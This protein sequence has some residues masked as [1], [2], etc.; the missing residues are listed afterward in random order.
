MLDYNFF[1]VGHV[2]IYPSISNV[3]ITYQMTVHKR[4]I[5]AECSPVV[6]KHKTQLKLMLLLLKL[7][8]EDSRRMVSRIFHILFIL[9]SFEIEE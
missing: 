5:E 7:Y 3:Y 2:D 6:S 9:H 4:L 8:L 1:A